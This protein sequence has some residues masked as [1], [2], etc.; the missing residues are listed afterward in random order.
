MGIKWQ[1]VVIDDS[2]LLNDEELFGEAITR[3]LNDY[4]AIEVIKLEYTTITPND[5]NYFEAII[6]REV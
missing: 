4:E 6:K 5:D 2:H 3:I 1:W